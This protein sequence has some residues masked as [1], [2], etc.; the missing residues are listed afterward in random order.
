MTYS[1]SLYGT[2]VVPF[3][4]LFAYERLMRSKV[5]QYI[6]AQKIEIDSLFMAIANGHQ[7]IA[8]SR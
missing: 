5:I 2:R 4:A 7:F 8:I 1:S 6:L 3:I